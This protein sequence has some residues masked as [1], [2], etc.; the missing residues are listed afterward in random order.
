M[1]VE[2]TKS[3]PQRLK[4]YGSLYILYH[5]QQTLKRIKVSWV[6]IDIE[7]V[8]VA[9][10]EPVGRVLVYFKETLDCTLLFFGQVIMYYVVACDI[11][12]LDDILPTLVVT[13]VGKIKEYYIILCHSVVKLF[14]V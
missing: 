2:Y 10:N 6:G 9:V 3:E 7:Q 1:R 5:L 12:L 8:A 4:L 14:A 11:V 13:A